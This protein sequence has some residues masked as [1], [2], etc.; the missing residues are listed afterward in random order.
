MRCARPAGGAGFAGWANRRPD[1]AATRH[2]AGDGG[3]SGFSPGCTA[4]WATSRHCASSTSSSTRVPA[5]RGR[6][7]R[8][9][10]W[11]HSRE[12]AGWSDQNGAPGSRSVHG[13][14]VV[15]AARAVAG[16]DSASAMARILGSALRGRDAP[17]LAQFP[18]QLEP[19]VDWLAGGL[20]RLPGPVVQSAYRRAGWA[21]AIN[22]RQLPRVRS[23]RLADWVVRQCPRRRYPVVFVGSSALRAARRSQPAGRRPVQGHL[24]ATWGAG[25]PAACQFVS[26]HG[27]DA[28]Y[29][30]WV[31]AVLGAV[32]DP[33]LAGPAGRL[34]VAFGQI[35]RH[36]ADHLP[37]RR[38][39]HQRP[40]HRRMASGAGQRAPAR[41][42]AR[43]RS[44]P[45][46]PAFPGTHRVS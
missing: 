29:A 46:S 27:S 35:R 3:A 30:H 42:V 34:L 43:R 22:A 21:D 39:V 31:G 2:P 19:A 37:A 4:C 10:V 24:R 13:T 41:R 26:A 33:A 32:R 38:A 28:G 23:D 45:L 15:S 40:R 8:W 6:W 1:P 12:V 44:R 16:F 14:P 5:C 9:R 36:P 7:A 11:G 18:A 17:L 20:E 25:R